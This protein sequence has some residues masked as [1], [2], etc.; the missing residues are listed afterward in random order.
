MPPNT[1]PSICGKWMLPIFSPTALFQADSCLVRKCWLLVALLAKGTT[2]SKFWRRLNVALSLYWLFMRVVP[3]HIFWHTSLKAQSAAFRAAPGC[4]PSRDFWWC[5]YYFEIKRVLHPAA[6]KHILKQL[7]NPL[8]HFTCWRL[9]GTWVVSR[10]AIA[11]RVSPLFGMGHRPDREL[12][13]MQWLKPLSCLQMFLILEWPDL[14][15]IF[16]ENQGW[17]TCTL[18]VLT[19][20]II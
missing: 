3:D 17:T 19:H 11:N 14:F 2:V 18:L 16:K 12:I 6:Q 7:L 10:F 9:L 4:L 15:Q 13:T 8:L 5:V 1:L 20:L